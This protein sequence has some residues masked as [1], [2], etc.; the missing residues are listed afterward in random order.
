[1]PDHPG[2]RPP[3]R[4]PLPSGPSLVLGAFVAFAGPLD[5]LPRRSSPYDDRHQRL[6]QVNTVSGTATTTTLY[7]N[8]PASGAMSEQVTQ[9]AT[10]PTTWNSFN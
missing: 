4:A 9:G 7:L 1:M 8:D 3:Y 6:R 2:Y 10:A 5:P